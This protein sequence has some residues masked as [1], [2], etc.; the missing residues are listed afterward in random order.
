MVRCLRVCH[1]LGRSRDALVPPSSCRI[2]IAWLGSRWGLCRC[3][4]C[5]AMGEGTALT[6]PRF[7]YA[8]ISGH[9]RALALNGLF[10]SV[11]WAAFVSISLPVTLSSPTSYLIVPGAG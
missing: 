2:V 10:P 6:P 8:P 5:P 11:P 4:F 7:L 1:L 3:H 9:S